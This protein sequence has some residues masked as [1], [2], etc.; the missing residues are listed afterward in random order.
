MSSGSVTGILNSHTLSFDEQECM[1]GEMFTYADEPFAAWSSHVAERVSDDHRG[2][3]ERVLTD[4][5]HFDHSV[6]SMPIC[7]CGAEVLDGDIT[8]HIADLI[9]S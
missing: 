4:H 2:S 7:A 6:S 9:E 8:R 3:I 5:F 1:C